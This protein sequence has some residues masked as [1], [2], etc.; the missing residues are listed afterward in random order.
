MTI[1]LSDGWQILQDVRDD[2]EALGLWR[3][4]DARH[5][6]QG[7]QLSD[8]EDLPR[9]AQ[10]QLVYAGNPYF[11]RELRYFNQ[12]P[13]WYRRVF[14]LPG[15]PGHVSLRFTNADY[16]CKVWLNG[17][18][19]NEHEG[20]S[21]PFTLD[22]TR[23]A[24]PGKNTLI[25]KV[26]SPWDETVAA[27]ALDKRTFAV[28]RRMVKG[29]YEHSDTFV[30]RDV[31]PVGLYGQVSVECETGARFDG[32]PAISYALDEGLDSA[33]IRACA[34]VEGAP[35]FSEL[36]LTCVDRQ[37]GE[38]LC[39]AFAP[40][41]LGEVR[42]RAEGIRPWNSW[43]RGG[44]WLYALRLELVSAGELL[45]AREWVT[46]FRKVDLVRDALRA[47][48]HLNGSRVYVRG[49]SY[50][51]DAYVSN[52]TEE[53]YLRDLTNIRALGFNLIRVH[54]HV[55][56]PRFYELCDELGLMV[57]QDSEYNWT[58]P[59]GAEFWT[60]FERVMTDTAHFLGHHP[61]VACWILMNEPNLMQGE[62][63]MDQGMALY[64]ALRAADPSRPVIRGSFLKDDL[65][66]GDSHNYAGS[67]NGAGG[68]YVD[69]FGTTEKFNTEYGFDAPPTMDSLRRCPRAAK[70]LAPIAD[71][72]LE[73]QRYQY[74]LLKYY[75]EHYRM[76]KY[77]PNAGYVQ[78]LYSDLC[79]QSFY[80]VYD[81]W[82]L[83]K[84][85]ARAMAESNQPVGA[86]LRYGR[87]RADS[88]WVVNDKLEPLGDVRVRWV[89][90]DGCG[91]LIA[92]SSAD[93][94]LGADSAASAAL[95]LRAERGKRM[96]VALVLTRGDEVIARNRY[97]DL[98]ALPAHVEGHPERMSHEL[99][100]RLY[101]S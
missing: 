67:L 81:H 82:G 36:R 19:I 34:R 101:F 47:E 55:E 54:V 60:R 69:I 57:I 23:A 49:T 98:F 56:Q 99:G 97:E 78:F 12:A 76:Q 5:E 86:F 68:H 59:G 8:W 70:R 22:A 24:R 20:Y 100:M 44:A 29:T 4:G 65:L 64:G 46:G 33:L 32:D 53:K 41:G 66:S 31:N 73:I 61:C 50:F 17:E 72:I 14:E 87:E 74:A 94:Y 71:R 40:A 28:E 90:T 27:E 63:G 89:C 75:T 7:D 85:G 91:G 11:G 6:A 39:E 43:D 1:D 58:H 77:A 79:P 2:G 83:P 52:M 21:T 42:A 35:E 37:T 45:S 16:Y 62:L 25:V 30:Q 15:N 51:P 80:G 92:Q 93:F 84:L 10:L 95:D 96:D 3:E 18:F 9:L 88:V 13:W 38:C 48:L 26:W